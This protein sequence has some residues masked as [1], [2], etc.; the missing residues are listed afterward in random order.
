MV[1]GGVMA[2]FYDTKLFWSFITIIVLIVIYYRSLKSYLE[3]YKSNG[4]SRTKRF[5]MGIPPLVLP[6]LILSI[7]NNLFALGLGRDMDELLLGSCI[8]SISMGWILLMFKNRK[9]RRN[10][11]LEALSNYELPKAY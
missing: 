5:H 4:K 7:V 1:F 3:L 9:K 6:L 10:I 11:H 8:G 2:F